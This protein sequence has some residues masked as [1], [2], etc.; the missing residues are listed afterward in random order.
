MMNPQKSC[1]VGFLWSPLLESFNF[2]NKHP[3]KVGRFKMIHDFILEHG[4]LENSNVRI[5]EPEP[6]SEDVLRTIHSKEYIAQVIEIS[7][8]GQGDI[9]I[10]TPGFKGIYFN[11][12]ITSGASVTGVQAILDGHIDHFLSPTGG[13]HHA[14]Y[15][16]GGGF[17]IFNDVAACVHE[18]KNNGIERILIADF[19]VHHG[20]G[21]QTYF[22]D[23]P[24]VMQISFHEDPEWMFPHDG[25]L[26]D[27]GQGPGL[28]YN[29]NMPFPMDS[30]DTVY[31]YAFDELVPPLISSYKPEF[32]LFIP[33]FDTHYLDRL[34][35]LKVTIDMIQYVASYMH[36]VAHEYSRGRLGVVTGGGYHS[37]S[38]QWGIGTVMSILTGHPYQAPHQ[39]PPFED[40]EET[41]AE[42]RHNVAR[43]K[44]LIFPFHDI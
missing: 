22:Y 13:F 30:G 21:T 29:I 39:N 3:I 18:L 4:F 27:I 12:R 40:D 33:G 5:I 38:L 43:L 44:E 1:R 28:G 37:E 25:F 24:G 11:G 32:I 8:T 16:N 10:D 36:K 6:L 35:H 23:D 19:D 42:V 31:R 2:G 34:A 14:K 20:N 26:E 15:E 7:G 41:V 9:D 17:C